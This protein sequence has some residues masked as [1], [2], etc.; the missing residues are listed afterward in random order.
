MLLCL[1][2]GLRPAGRSQDKAG[3]HPS[4]PKKMTN[5][6]KQIKMEASHPG[7]RRAEAPKGNG[8]VHLMNASG[9][10]RSGW[11]GRREK[12]EMRGH[13]RRLQ[14]EGERAI[15]QLGTNPLLLYQILSQ[16]TGVC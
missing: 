1:G 9:L 2:E 7:W 12:E 13:G 15:M 5:E 4:T 14:K 8:E 3:S 6:R 11:K 10:A 16:P